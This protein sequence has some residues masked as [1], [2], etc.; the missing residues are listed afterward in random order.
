EID[1]AQFGDYTIFGDGAVSD[2]LDWTITAINGVATSLTGQ[3]VYSTTAAGTSTWANGFTIDQ[4]VFGTAA[5]KIAIEWTDTIMVESAS[6]TDVAFIKNK[7]SNGFC[8]TTTAIPEPGSLGL[9]LIGAI[10]L[11]R[12]R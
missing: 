8:V 4:S 5:T 7:S 3:S 1:F 12:R 9:L 6:V 11:I 10:G 2:T